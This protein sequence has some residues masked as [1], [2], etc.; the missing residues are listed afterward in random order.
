MNVKVFRAVRVINGLD[1]YEYAKEIGAS[2]SLVS[3]IDGG[4]RNLTP[5]VSRLVRERFGDEY[6][7]MVETLIEMNKVNFEEVG[8][9]E[10]ETE[11]GA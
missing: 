9:D 8:E 2:R 11:A 4:Y 3:K 1:Q 5:D 7:E 6:T 10:E